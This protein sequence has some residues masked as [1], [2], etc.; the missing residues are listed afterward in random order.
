VHPYLPHLLND[1]AIAHRIGQPGEISY[2]KSIEEEMEDIERW[3][4]GEDHPQTFG[5]YCGLKAENF[6]PAE[7]LTTEEMEM[8]NK[9]FSYMMFTWNHSADFP[10][11]LPTEI[12]YSMLIDTLNE[13]TFIPESGFVSFDYCT[14]Y[15]PN[16]IFKEYCPCL[17]IWNSP[18]DNDMSLPGSAED[19][20]PF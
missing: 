14:G 6:P 2:T 1:I 13:K 12:T 9:A 15:A 18:S 19:E 10:G 7:Q 5:N 3:V 4:E 17:E 8:V 16:C 11:D 20:L